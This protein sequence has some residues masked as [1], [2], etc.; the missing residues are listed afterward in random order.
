[1]LSSAVA[2]IPHFRLTSRS[3]SSGR[4]VGVNE[5]Q[6][7]FLTH[8]SVVFAKMTIAALPM[9]VI[10]VLGHRPIHSRPRRRHGE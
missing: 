1:M 10:F 6:S 7:R 8:Y 4:S 5:S 2:L 3:A 9:V